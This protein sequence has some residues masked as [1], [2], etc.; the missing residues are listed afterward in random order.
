MTGQVFKAG[1]WEV[2]LRHRKLRRSGNEVPLGGRAFEILELLVRSAGKVVTKQEVMRSVWPGATVSENT[3]HVHVSAIRVA[4]GSDRELLKTVTG[5]GYRLIG[6]WDELHEEVPRQTARAAVGGVRSARVSNLP[7]AV[8]ELIGRR[9]AIEHLRDVAS[10]YRVVTLVGLGGVGKTRLAIELART[11]VQNFSSGVW[12]VDL[13]PISDEHHVM[14]TVHAALNLTVT[15]ERITA[16]AIAHALADNE[17]LVVLDNCEHVIDEVAHLTEVI[18]RT[19]P[20]LTILATS[21]EVLRVEGEHVFRVPPLDVPSDEHADQSIV[22]QS[23]AVALFLARMEAADRLFSPG[24]DD[25]LMVAELCRRLDG[26]PLAIELTAAHTATLGLTE[27]LSRFARRL[28]L[29]GGGRRT[30]HPRHRTLSAT[31]DWSYRLLSDPERTV[32][33]YVSVFRG[34]FTLD[35]AVAVANGTGLSP[36]TVTNSVANLVSKSLITIGDSADSSRFRLLESTREYANGK[37]EESAEG[38]KARCAHAAY[39]RDLFQANEPRS[40][41]Q[42]SLVVALPFAQELDNVRA[43]LDWAFSPEGDPAIG[44]ILTATFG[45]GWLQLSLVA[46][47]RE[48]AERALNALDASPELG[49]RFGKEIYITLGVAIYP[50]VG[51]FR[52]A[53]SAAERYARLAQRSGDPTRLIMADHLMGQTLHLGGR[54]REAKEHLDRVLRAPIN[55]SDHP[56]L[57]PFLFNQRIAATAILARTL[58]VMGFADQARDAVTTALNDSWARNDKLSVCY[59]LAR[60]GGRVALIAG[61][62]AMAEDA[63]TVLIQL[64]Q[65]LDMPFWR[66]IAE[67]LHGELLIR[68]G[69]VDTGCQL[70][71]GALD[72]MLH[73]RR[74]LHHVGFLYALAEGLSEAG[75]VTE[76]LSTIDHAF[77]KADS[78]GEHWCVAELYRV[79]GLLLCKAQPSTDVGKSCFRKAIEIAGSQL[80]RAWQL[81]ATL[82]LARLLVAE[83]RHTDA[84]AQLLPV[85]RE[86][87]E[88]FNALDMVAS[89]ELLSRC[90]VN[91]E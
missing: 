40:L 76:G 20:R 83:A 82:S 79:R 31:L 12:I 70:L 28:E 6:E 59:T 23:G 11:L 81:R 47:C 44:I 18:V 2:D 33:K 89:R 35:A 7:A 90:G 45:P 75:R 17:M 72:A 43:A 38:H 5:R 87:T 25:L 34:G 91:L 30:A 62:F 19:C 60:A 22:A 84:V 58:A 14:T 74:A 86:F 66:Q 49:H 71:K 8:S 73:G 53:Q 27:L 4:L 50:M 80:A 39:Y 78:D 37:L 9:A 55:L 1:P 63:I 77:A 51:E 42:P 57:H 24:T 46:E 54:Q 32:F 88:G 48:Q 61:D 3:V 68:Q 41:L 29:P 64:S 10:A 21:R 67:C 15:A 26:L 69:N 52:R 13:A 16:E 65:E 56:E 36:Q 85:Y